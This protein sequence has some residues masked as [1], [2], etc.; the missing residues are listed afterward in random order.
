[1]K[2]QN[3]QTD[4]VA[5]LRY[6]AAHSAQLEKLGKIARQKSFASL[7]RKPVVA[8]G[9]SLQQEDFATFYR[10]GKELFAEH[11]M[12]VQEAPDAFANKNL[13]LMRKLDEIGLLQIT[14]A[15]CN[16]RMFGYLM[17]LVSPALEEEGRMSAIHTTFFASKDA[18]NLGMKLQRAS[19]EG[20]RSRG[21]DEVLFR[22]GTRGSGPRM[23]ALYRRMGAEFCG[24]DYILSLKKG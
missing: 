5:T 11:L 6:C 2:S 18:P 21:V 13:P 9:M 24:E 14:T 19:V 17:A 7:A 1:M 4:M 8:E 15:R 23:A 10:D 22:A 3:L 12:Q 20:L 16:G